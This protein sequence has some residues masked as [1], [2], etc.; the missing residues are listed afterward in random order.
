MFR[1]GRQQEKGFRRR[2]F[3]AVVRSASQR[4]GLVQIQQNRV[5]KLIDA[6]SMAEPGLAKIEAAKLDGTWNALDAVENLEVPPDLA[7]IF[8]AYQGS[9]DNFDSFP[10]WVKRAILEWISTAKRKDTRNGRI[11]ETARLAQSNE[12]PKQWR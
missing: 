3:D 10:R 7:G 6:G 8:D 12:R 5:A 1:L 4:V 11:E 9:A 2:S